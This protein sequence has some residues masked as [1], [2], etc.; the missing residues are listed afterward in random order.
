MFTEHLPLRRALAQLLTILTALF[1][2]AALAPAALAANGQP[3]ARMAVAAPST[4][5]VS[6]SIRFAARHVAPGVRRVVFSID[7]SHR[8]T[9]LRAPYRY[10]RTGVLNTR[11]LRNGS[12]LLVVKAIMAGR[13]VRVARQRVIVHNAP[14][15]SARPGRSTAPKPRPVAPVTVAGPADI[16]VAPAPA[17]G[18]NGPDVALFNR[19]SYQFSTSLPMAQ[20]AGRYSYFVLQATDARLIP[21]PAP[22]QPGSEDLHV[23]GPQALPPVRHPGPDRVQHLQPARRPPRLVHPRQRR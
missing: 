18:P 3:V 15:P 17:A 1:A 4:G 20:E 14:A 22:A 16:G 21:L 12:H 23:P 2:L 6:G 10:H 9:A 11:K 8:W 19:V 5:T 13:G 7:G